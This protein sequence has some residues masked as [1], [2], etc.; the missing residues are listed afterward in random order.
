M[1]PDK[2]QWI[3]LRKK[4][5][6]VKDLAALTAATGHEFAIFTGAS[7]KILVHGTSKS[8]HIPHEAWNIIKE[9]Q[10]EW[11]AHSHPTYT[12]LE[13]SDEDIKTLSL[14]TWQKKV[15]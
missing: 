11:T 8:W 3:E 6:D 2:G 15:L 13:E 7:S 14:F 5:V 4:Q 1:I 9:N 12:K 10:Y